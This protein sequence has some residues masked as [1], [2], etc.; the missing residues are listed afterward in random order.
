MWKEII[1]LLFWTEN[2]SVGLQC[3]IVATENKIAV[4]KDVAV[5]VYSKYFTV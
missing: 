2:V 5:R 4:K 3:L 1:V